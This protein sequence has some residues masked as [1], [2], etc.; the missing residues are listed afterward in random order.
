MKIRKFGNILESG[1]SADA[2]NLYRFVAKMASLE[3]SED[4]VAHKSPIREWYLAGPS[5]PQRRQRACVHF[6]WCNL[7]TLLCDSRFS[8]CLAF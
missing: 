4:L 3:G 2:N 7:R 5:N 6:V 8:E 1:M